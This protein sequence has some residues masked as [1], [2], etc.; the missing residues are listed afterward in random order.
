MKVPA[1]LPHIIRES[2]FFPIV[3]LILIYLL[4]WVLNL[5][6]SS[7][8]DSVHLASGDDVFHLLSWETIFSALIGLVHFAVILF[9]IVTWYFQHYEIHHDHI[10]FRKGVFFVKRKMFPLQ[11]VQEIS[12]KQS[13]IGR[14]F[15]YGNV[16]LY[17]PSTD[18]LLRLI[19]IPAVGRYTF[20][21][22]DIILGK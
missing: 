3:R 13:L 22:R 16:I 18:T 11:N 19:R 15:D 12:Y 1:D 21:M 9:I 4:F 6:G 5:F 8:L 17:G 10:A 2:L 7:I 20:L 14:I